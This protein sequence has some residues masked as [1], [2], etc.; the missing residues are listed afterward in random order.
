MCVGD[1]TNSSKNY[2]FLCTGMLGFQSDAFVMQY[3]N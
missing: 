3:N 2:H 1:H